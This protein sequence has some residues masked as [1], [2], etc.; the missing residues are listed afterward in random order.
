MKSDMNRKQEPVQLPLERLHRFPEHPYKV[1]DNEE[2][3][4]LTESIREYGVLNPLL[5]RRMEGSET[6]YELVSGHRRAYAAAKAGLETV[7]AFVVSLD[8]NEAAIAL[9]D[10]NLHRERLLPSEKAFAYKLKMEALKR[11]GRRSDLTSSQLETKFRSDEQ[12]GADAGESR[13]QVQ[14]YIRLTYLLPELLDLMDEGK[15]AF[16]VGV[17]LSYLPAEAQYDLL[18]AMRMN[19]CTPSYSQA[20]RLHRAASAGALTPWTAQ[21][22]MV[23]QKPN[24]RD[25]IRFRRDELERFFPVSYTDAQIK[26]DILAGLALLQKQR[27]RE[28]NR[29]ER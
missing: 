29:D 22:V 28:R 7:P 23:E 2:M 10:S 4:A 21:E 20:V 19:D 13:A 8:R 15:I 5:V 25:Q 9:V 3:E 16:S 1:E 27:Q 24:Q 17:E 6:D 14:R 26:Q 12:I 18:E 11:Q